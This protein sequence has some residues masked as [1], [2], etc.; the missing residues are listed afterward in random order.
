MWRLSFVVL[1][2]AGAL[3]VG[4]SGSEAD[5][6]STEEDPVTAAK[7]IY[8]ADLGPSGIEFYTKRGSANVRL[9]I[10]GELTGD[11]DGPNTGSVRVG[12]KDCE[13]CLYFQKPGSKTFLNVAKAANK[14][15]SLRKTHFSY[16][17]KGFVLTN[18]IVKV[19]AEAVEGGTLSVTWP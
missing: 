5:D 8:V 3:S 1:A 14:K 2:L 12:G 16:E 6:L 9:S 13:T 11:E 10:P 17:A 7:T 15:L 18:P 4:C 19:K